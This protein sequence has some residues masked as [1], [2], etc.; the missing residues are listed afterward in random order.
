MNDYR[1]KA[2]K[3]SG[4]MKALLSDWMIVFLFIILF[5]LCCFNSNFRTYSNIMNVLR[6]ASF[7]AI[8]AMGEFFVILIGEMD[9]SIS[10]IIGMVSI[11][12]AGL[13]VKN[14]LPIWLAI[15]VVL[16]MS[17]IIGIINGS[18]VVYGKMP[19]FIATLV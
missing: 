6:Q 14:N 11:F 8:I 15:M 13:V 5:I 10:S 19:S 3:Y 18:L 9:M 2:K 7:L 1:E 12:F 16:L 4:G 17:A